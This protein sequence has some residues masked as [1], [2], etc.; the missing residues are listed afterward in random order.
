MMEGT[1]YSKAKGTSDVQGNRS[2]EI[3]ISVD[4]SNGEKAANIQ[5]MENVR[6]SLH[7]LKIDCSQD[8][9]PGIAVLGSGGGLRAMI[10][11]QGT[12]QEL[13]NQ[14]LLGTVK[15]LCGVSGSTWCM[16][17]LYKHE[18]WPKKLPTLE[19]GLCE[20]L[21]GGSWE[22]N[23]LLDALGAA[24]DEDDE[25]SL[26]DFWA[27]AIIYEMLSELDEALLSEQDCEKGK[28]PYPIYAA[29]DGKRLTEASK[30]SK[31]IW[32]E[33]TP[34]E[35][36]F[37]SPGGFVST[38]HFGSE[39]ENAELKKKNKQKN[40]GYLRGLW[41]SALASSEEIKKAIIDS[42]K[43]FIF[44]R[45]VDAAHLQEEKKQSE[46]YRMRSVL[47]DERNLLRKDAQVQDY[48][49]VCEI[50]EKESVEAAKQTPL[51]EKASIGVWT[52]PKIAFKTLPLL[53]TWTWGSNR[54]FLYKCCDIQSG[55]LA[56]DDIISLVDA[57][58]AINSA[59][60]LLLRPE[61]KVNLILS[62][63]FSSGDPF[64]TV[65]M[66]AK[67]CKENNIPFPKLDEKTLEKDKDNP[68]NCYIFQEE[69]APTV[70]H[71]PLFNRVNCE[72]KID[73]WNEKYSIFK[74]SSYTDQ[75]IRDLLRVAKQNV[76]NLNTKERILAEIQN[77]VK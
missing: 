32:F 52:L 61:R 53:R 10:A 26:T 64:E 62:F 16:S 7:E 44:G 17:Y 68:E 77:A 41:G 66:A 43:Q 40:I 37:P 39:F 22:M 2:Q 65:K 59:Y 19:K 70:I 30:T 72:G 4:L 8:N 63:D 35:A 24:V 69:N 1:E 75:E 6:Q 29:V 57:G 15:Y 48:V 33:F 21:A 28:A 45:N 31:E 71:I 14:N 12:L 13:E 42:L 50:L 11:L 25:Y 27:Y 9:V 18:D 49:T 67:Y 58:L 38:T 5:R 60:P 34:H 3:R 20:K 76:S 23:K 36:G 73:E 51:H 46:T 55:D 54:N 74:L 56:N 47:K